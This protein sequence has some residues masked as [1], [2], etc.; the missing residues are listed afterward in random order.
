[1]AV[2][3]VPKNQL[4]T[5]EYDALLDFLKES[6]FKQSI[7]TKTADGFPAECWTKRLV[8]A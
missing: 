1:M 6:G 7:E 3:I 4:D 2:L 8:D 5:K